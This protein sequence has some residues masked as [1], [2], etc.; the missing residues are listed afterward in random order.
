VAVVLL[1]I[2]L[3]SGGVQVVKTDGNNIVSAVGR[4][5]PDGLVLAHEGDGDLRGDAAEGT[6]V[7]AYIDEVPC[8]RVG[9]VCLVILSSLLSFHILFRAVVYLSDVLRHCELVKARWPGWCFGKGTG[10]R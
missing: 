2:A 1:L 5:V 8:A 3:L 6:G 9:E 4:G 10:A 7:S